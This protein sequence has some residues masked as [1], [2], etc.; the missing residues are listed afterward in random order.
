[1]KIYNLCYDFGLNVICIPRI[2]LLVIMFP[3]KRAAMFLLTHAPIVSV[4]LLGSL[5][6]CFN[7]GSTSLLD[8]L[9]P[10]IDASSKYIPFS[11]YF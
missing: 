8:F 11:Y 3:P 4:I 2:L 5:V 7:A 9:F 6:C 10:E 1:M